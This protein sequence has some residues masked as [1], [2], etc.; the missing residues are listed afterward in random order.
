MTRLLALLLPAALTGC[1]LLLG[2]D[3]HFVDGVDAAPLEDDGGGDAQLVDAEGPDARDGAAHRDARPAGDSS[4]SPDGALEAA[5]D[6]GDGALDAAEAE[7]ACTPLTFRTVSCGASPNIVGCLPTAGE[8][9]GLDSADSGS[10][11]MVPAACTCAETY[12]CAC[13]A[14]AL[15]PCSADDAGNLTVRP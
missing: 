12:T 8:A 3:F 9:C 10:C 13:L 11:P 6:A 14:G 5:L 2:D 4:S 15:G 7:A 1:P